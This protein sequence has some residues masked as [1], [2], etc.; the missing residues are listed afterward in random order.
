MPIFDQGYQH[1][2]G[3][4]S[5]RVWRWVTI[6]R[7]GVR[8]QRGNRLVRIL[9][10]IAWVQALGLIGVMVVWGFVE[11]QSEGVLTA[12]S[13][14]PSGILQDPAAYRTTVW[15]LAYS[16]FFKAEIFCIMLLVAIAGP[17]LI[18]QDLRFN[19]IP[20][21]LTRPLTRLDY[22]LGKLG[23]IGALV[24]SVAVGPALFAYMV[25]ICF[26][27]DLNV[28]KDTYPILLG[29]IVYGFIITVSA[30]TLILALSSLTRRSLYVG[31]TWAGFW[32]ISSMVGTI[33][34]TIHGESVRLELRQE[35]LNRWLQ[36][37]PPP[38][39][40]QLHNGFPSVQMNQKSG[41][42]RPT[43][44]AP[45]HE[46]EGER[47]YDAW[48]GAS[49]TAWIKAQNRQREVLR[50]DWRPLFS[51]VSNL[52]RFADLMLDTD[53]AWVSIGRAVE[54]ARQVTFA[55]GFV[56]RGPTRR[57]QRALPESNEREIADRMVPQYPWWWS[58][59]VLAG[60]LGISTWIL[61]RRV[62]SLDR[63]K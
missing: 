34:S 52:E 31:I 11:R 58:A 43:G 6:A 45:G 55:R 62:K 22:F 10:L 38:P 39:G 63:L 59:Y 28:V 53:S 16:F 57:E 37:H 47:W 1:W 54:R 46:D 40:V 7:Q 33:L 25:G 29:S 36:E 26:C 14:L 18:S 35:E 3:P 2:K 60:L 13:W 19:A 20:L 51:Y 56:G 50:S 23:V 4:L 9:M 41:R 27:L 12:L 15:T 8:V 17:G 61:T 44:I 5:G 48:R 49:Q 42:Y 24:A 30:G 21:Y 32:I